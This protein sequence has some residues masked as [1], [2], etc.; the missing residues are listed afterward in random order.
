M[1]LWVT[2]TVDYVDLND[3]KA[4]IDEAQRAVLFLIFK[5]TPARATRC[6]TPSSTCR[7][8]PIARSGSTS[9]ARLTRTLLHQQDQVPIFDPDNVVHADFEVVLPAAIDKAT[10]WFVQELK[11]LPR[12]PSRWC[13]A[14]WCSST[15]CRLTRS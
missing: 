9:R 15:R 1:T 13:T 5:K 2:P 7:G 6:S 11:K 14:R 12:T 8:R 10:S 3:A 4:A